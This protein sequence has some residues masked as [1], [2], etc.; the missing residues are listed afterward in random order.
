MDR[1]PC[2]FAQPLIEAAQQGTTAGERD[3]AVHDVAGKLG[4]ALAERG[5]DDV[6]DGADGSL[7]RVPDLLGTDH[8]GLRQAADQVAAADLGV[9]FTGRRAGRP[10]R[11]LDLLGGPFAQ[12]ERVLLLGED[13]DRLVH[14]VAAGPD[15][16]AGHDAAER[17]HR[18]LGGPAAHVHNHGAGRL[19]HRQ[20]G[21]DRGRHRLL[22]DVNAAGPGLVPGFLHRALLHAGDP[23]GHSHHQPR[24]GKVPALVHRLDEVAQHPL[25]DIEV[26]D[27][28]V[29]QR[30]DRHDVPRRPADH[31]FRLAA[32][33][34]RSCRYRY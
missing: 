12:H 30:P 27:D 1:H 26:G 24:P 15:G 7:D 20:P 34:K 31:P 22:D 32:D 14:F 28:T 16:L 13:D 17:D 2:L 4:R 19:V 6:H 23:A 11:H 21:A 25:G 18:H 9:R 8:D 5:F 29:L 3:T 10:D 33:R